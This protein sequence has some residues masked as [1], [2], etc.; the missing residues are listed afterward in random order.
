MH[1][2][3]IKNV[4]KGG[5]LVSSTIQDPADLAM[6]IEQAVAWHEDL[7]KSG[8]KLVITNGCFDIMHR[9]HAQ[10]LHE[11]RSFGDA[12]LVLQNSDASVAE[13]KGPSRPIINQE[14]RAYM[15]ASLQCVDAVVTFEGQRC[16]KE[17]EALKP[18]I[19]VKGGDYT[20]ETLNP[21][22]RQA[23]QNGGAEF[24][25]IPFIP[26]CSTTEVLAKLNEEE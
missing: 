17:F 21:E 16:T 26:G 5:K 18:E 15:L 1:Q 6:T 23:L 10:Y 11:A 20:L 8:K 14:N 25:F 3:I 19:Y 4:Y 13:L 22:E 9:G 2:S 7:K 12:M 24:H